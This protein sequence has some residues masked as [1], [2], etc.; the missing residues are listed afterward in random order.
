MA[1]ARLTELCCRQSLGQILTLA[2]RLGGRSRATWV[3]R[4]HTHTKVSVSASPAF[5]PL[6][7]APKLH[8]GNYCGCSSSN[9]QNHLPQKFS[10]R[11]I[12][13]PSPWTSKPMQS[14]WSSRHYWRA[15]QKEAGLPC[16]VLRSSVI[17][18][19]AAGVPPRSLW[20]K[21]C[22]ISAPSQT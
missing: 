15:Q 4:G 18:G 9:P 17:H 7:S 12:A 13:R 5:F 20:K 16:E 3:F 14:L 10:I 2:H 22:S 21:R 1:A 19:P 11:L 6:P 8:M